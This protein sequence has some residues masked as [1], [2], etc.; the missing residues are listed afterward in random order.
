MLRIILISLVTSLLS[1]TALAELSVN[2][3]VGTWKR[4]TDATQYVKINADYSWDAQLNVDDQI[5]K[6][7][8]MSIMTTPGDNDS[9]T[10]VV[11]LSQAGNEDRSNVV[12]ALGSIDTSW[13]PNTTLSYD[14]LVLKKEN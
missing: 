10:L 1:F 2:D 14:D 6:V 7:S 4:T 12:F 13:T 3:L 8:G 11:F 5:V 9:G